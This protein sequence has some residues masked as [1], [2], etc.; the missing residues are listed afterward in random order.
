MSQAADWDGARYDQVSGPQAAW[1]RDVLSR[2]HLEGHETVMDAGCGSGRVTEELLARL[3]EGRVVALDASGSMLAEARARLAPWEG[4][5]SF[6]HTDLLSLR[7]ELLGNDAPVDAVLSTATF[8][9]VTDHATLF[10]NLRAVMRP[11]G[12]LVAQCGGEGNIQ[13]L[14]DT[15]R[16]LGV[17]RAGDWLYASP[18]ATAERLRATGFVKVS[19]WDNPELVRFED[20]EALVDFLQTV[21]LRQHL[22]N[23]AP[24]ERRPFAEHVADA[25]PEPVLDYVRLNIVAT[26]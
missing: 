19:T 7:P 8:H 10:A 13:G 20:R 25:M 17:E 16:S 22:G 1:G 9:W 21:C 2:L 3:P 23:L 18:E 4:Q 12:Q 6:C 26:A 11:G 14:I 15:V 5:V 24:E